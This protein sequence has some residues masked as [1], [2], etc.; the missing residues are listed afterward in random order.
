MDINEFPRGGRLLGGAWTTIFK[1]G[2]RKSN[3]W[4]SVRFTNNHV[5]TEN[6]RKMHSAPFFRGTGECKR[7]ECN[8]KM[9][10]VIP[11]ER[12]K[13]VYVTYMGNVHH[14]LSESSVSET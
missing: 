1:R 14:K 7:E 10:F 6:S 12:G 11:E 4:Y 5:R 8:V 9:K 2:V 13:Y 3:R